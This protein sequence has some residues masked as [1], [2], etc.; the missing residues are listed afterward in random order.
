M[1]DRTLITQ[2]L[3]QRYGSAPEA[4]AGVETLAAMAGRGSCRVYHPEPLPDPLLDT[5]A[6]VALASPTKSDLQQRDI[7]FVED[8]TLRIWINSLFPEM[9]WIVRAPH[10]VIFLGNNRRL[11]RV[12]ER[13][14]HAFANDHLDA[15]F[16]AAVDAGIALSAFVTAAEHLG[17]GT[18][19]ISALRDHVAAV[20]ERLALPD[21]VFPICGLTLGRP[22]YAP[23]ISP[24]LAL[25]H[26][27]HRDIF[28]DSA[29][30]AGLDEYDQRRNRIRPFA[31]QRD[32]A[33]FG[34]AARYSWSEDKA[35]QYAV[36]QR[37]DFGAYIR[38]T[39]F[40]LE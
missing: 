32:T 14:G 21:H 5:L 37:S 31:S 24:R 9:P 38:K 15:F 11:R 30:D 20:S 3:H 8:S 22:V 23:R 4:G 18:C 19:P 40:K 6:A 29:V 17:L 34:T 36:P 10:F 35:R 25:P 12:H 1:T 13:Q 33:R 27:I 28:D 26:T 39:G 2:L 7:L 16:N